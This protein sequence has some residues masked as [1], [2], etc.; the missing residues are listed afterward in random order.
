MPEAITSGEN[1]FHGGNRAIMGIPQLRRAFEH[2]QA[3]AHKL[4]ASKK[5]SKESID[6]FISVWHKEFGKP[7]TADSAKSYLE[8][9]QSMGPVSSTATKANTRKR[10]LKG[11]AA[12]IAATAAPLDYK[13]EPGVY[14]TYGN[15]PAY[16]SGGFEVGVPRI[17]QLE[18]W[19]RIDTTPLVSAGIGSNQAGGSINTTS[20]APR[21][22]RSANKTRRLNPGRRR[23]GGHLILPTNPPSVIGDAVSYWHGQTLPPSPA[24]VDVGPRLVL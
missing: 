23:G 21:K 16:V 19:G 12:P 11:G 15:F 22:K 5:L 1:T 7:L 8:H 10:T 20:V 6:E 17:S 18:G 14:G 3:T 4:I 9:L 2:V 13:T 24:A